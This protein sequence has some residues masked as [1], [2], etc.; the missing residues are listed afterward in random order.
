MPFCQGRSGRYTVIERACDLGSRCASF[1]SFAPRHHAHLNSVFLHRPPPSSYC[2]HSSLAIPDICEIVK[3][4]TSCRPLLP[5][6]L[7]CVQPARCELYFAN[8]CSTVGT[9]KSYCSCPGRK[10]DPLAICPVLFHFNPIP[11]WVLANARIIAFLCQLL[12]CGGRKYI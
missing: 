4:S 1:S 8:R 11:L 2:C 10:D 7:K 9:T 12:S 3:L 5:L 6:L